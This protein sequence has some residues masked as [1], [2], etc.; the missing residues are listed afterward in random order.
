MGKKKAS[1]ASTMKISKPSDTK[2]LSNLI[3]I[4]RPKVYIT[5]SST[6]KTLVQELTGNGKG[7]SPS[8]S[9]CIPQPVMEIQEDFHDHNHVY[10]ESSSHSF[11]LSPAESPEMSFPGAYYGPSGSSPGLAVS[12]SPESSIGFNERMEFG[13][14]RD[15]ESWLLEIDQQHPFDHQYESYAPLADHSEGI[16]LFDGDFYQSLYDIL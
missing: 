5:D 7:E 2:N 14:L 3:K 8:S 16:S 9:Q 6:F 4:L 11:A 15:I 12:T 13:R 10:Q 1:K